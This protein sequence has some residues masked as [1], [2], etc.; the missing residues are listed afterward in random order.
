M[1]LL[2]VVIGLIIG[3]P[4]GS[5]GS[6]AGALAGG[7]IGHWL[8]RQGNKREP[9]V[10]P[11]FRQ[12]LQLLENQVQALRREV[13]VLKGTATA[14][15]AV[16]ESSWETPAPA[17]TSP[18]PQAVQ[19]P[20]V[21]MPPQP[22]P[23][24]DSPP[25]AARPVT[26]Q[27]FTLEPPDWAR[28]LWAINPLAKIG[29]VLLF[30]GIASGLRLAVDYGLLPVPLRLL[31]AAASGI[32]MIAFGWNRAGEE[33]HRTFGQAL[34]GGGFA[35]LYLVAYFMLQR[36]T[37]IGQGPAFALFALL[38]IACVFLAARQ[39]APVLAVLG[40]SGAF[41]APILAGGQ[42]D[43][44]LPLFAYFTLLNVFILAVDWFRAWRV[45]NIAGFFFT[46]AVGMAWA[47]DGYQ[48]RHYL[49]TQAFLVLFLS[50]YSA[51]PVATA[52]LRAPGLAA[53][54]DGILLFGTPLAG[55][56]LQARL[57]EGERYGLAWSTLIAALWYFGLWALLF[58]R[59]EPANLLV[60]R[61]HLGIA[62]VFLTI[63]IPLAFDAQ[64]TS[65]FW[66]A[67]GAAVLWFGV[68]QERKLAQVSGFLM[69]LAAGLS[70]LLGW[71]ALGH[72]LPVANDA[73]LGAF[74]LV[75]AGLFSARQLRSRA[76]SA[77][78]LPFLPW[79]WAM[80]W[81]L[82]P[83]LDEIY[84][85]APDSLHAPYALLFITATVL[86]QEGLISLWRWPQLR[87]AAV[88]LLVGLVVA[89]LAGI[90]RHGHPLAGFMALV[91]PLALAVH[92]VLLARHERQG[93]TGLAA[94]R[95][96][97]AWWLLLFA[98]AWELAWQAR[99]LMPAPTLWSFVAVVLVLAAGLALP[100]LGQQRQRWPF[101]AAGA[102][103]IP[104]GVLPP[105]FGLLLLLPW[106]N[107]R[108]SGLD[109]LGWPYLPLLN[110]FDAGQLAALGALVL[111]G[112][113]LAAAVAPLLRVLTALLA[114]L[115][116]SALA[117]RI[118]H[119]WGGIPFNFPTLM[120]AT[121]FQALLTLFWSTTAIATMIH[122]SR[123]E[124]RHRWFGGMLLL[125][126]VGAKLLLFDTMGRGTLTWTATLI[127]V[128]LLVLAAGYFAPLPPKAAAD[129]PLESDTLPGI[130]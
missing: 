96:L 81:W 87:P 69:Q 111:L 13:E 21:A 16:A 84:R 33:K 105:L 27:P 51:M 53:W 126:L 45:L 117:A 35:L 119:H 19:A 113:Q 93:E 18:V 52:L 2:G 80:L 49:L 103:Y 130:T 37:M 30:F 44:P 17:P 39:D 34:Q 71:A 57:M 65:A 127:G 110:I 3:S 59:R 98:L 99:H 60:E 14:S 95:H 108:L 114:F 61:S 78:L 77:A 91:L 66:A 64:V 97:G 47:M 121:L 129:G 11:D 100:V 55:T 90:G 43:S 9:A 24:A 104:Y 22:A 89:T 5:F 76:S 124:L 128:A 83:G 48:P 94:I 75:L 41:L 92:Y 116:L 74:I 56:F 28:R 62:V 112:R 40:L 10:G 32:A 68:R 67:E 23:L 122:A 42:A 50:V 125:G 54:R 46:L 29:I 115:W 36:Y 26:G 106:G 88:L 1:W 86:L 123:R 72:R 38:G 20:P 7:L 120:H 70:L 79:A 63:A 101:T 25:P 12:R 118:A 85:F 15:T 58:R 107:L 109:G 4:L 102:G 31:I 73:M 6:L 82:G 8:G